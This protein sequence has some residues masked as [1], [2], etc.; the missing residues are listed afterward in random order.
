MLSVRPVTDEDCRLLWEW[1]NDPGVRVSA[2]QSHPIAWNE[3]CAWFRAK[4]ADA[5][6]VMFIVMDD[7]QRPVGQVRF[8]PQEQNG[9]A[10]VAISIAREWRG[11]GYG[12][13]AVRL[14][15]AA[16]RRAGHTVRIMAY[17][18]PENLASVRAFEKV[19]FA[20]HGRKFIRGHDA[21]CMSHELNGYPAQPQR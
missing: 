7:A 15:C 14:A 2:F 5:R 4:R 17:I 9:D 11:R 8:E 10:E 19:G 13:E 1:V 3:H 18:K 21:V 12:T 16:Y 6:W 20:M